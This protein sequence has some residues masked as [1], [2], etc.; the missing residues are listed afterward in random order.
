M[1]D[2]G[3]SRE[4]SGLSDVAWRLE[5]SMD[6]ELRR[7]HEKALL[8]TYYNSLVASSKVDRS[9]YTWQRL[10]IEYQLASVPAA[11]NFFVS[12]ADLAKKAAALPD[13]AAQQKGTT[14]VELW[15]TRAL[16][17]VGDLG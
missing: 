2:F 16:T 1:I 10:I 13:T 14:I 7:K 12:A 5:S 9:E 17:H 11:L 6:V 3:N 8:S 15:V 4:D